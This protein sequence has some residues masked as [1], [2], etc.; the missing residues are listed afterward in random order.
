MNKEDAYNIKNYSDDDLYNIL[1][2]INPSDRELEAKINSNILKYSNIDNIESKQLS[3]L[4]SLKHVNNNYQN[5]LRMY[6]N[7]FLI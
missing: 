4:L 5:F 7:V 1:D 2:L 3:E 6:M